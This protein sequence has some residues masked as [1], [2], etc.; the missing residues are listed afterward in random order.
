MSKSRLT[1]LCLVAALAA[2]CGADGESVVAEAV[3]ESTWSA[4]RWSLGSTT[5]RGVEFHEAAPGFE[6]VTGEWVFD[7]VGAEERAVVRQDAKNASPVF[8]V[9]L[10]D[11]TAL[12]LELEVQ[13][14]AVDGQIDQGG[15]LVW[16]AKDGENYYIA[17]FN[18]L[19][20]NYRVYT[21]VDGVRTQLA[22]AEATIDPGAWIA[23]TVSMR[24]DH[25]QCEL[26]GRRLLDVRDDT[27]RDGGRVGLWTKADART[28]FDDLVLRA[29]GR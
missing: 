19:E 20:N 18:P 26:D 15:G 8:N 6:I 29:L 22:S 10:A 7:T 2:S 5:L 9:A 14:R 28:E 13:L 27:F 25:I 4:E 16:R 3:A 23:L 12:D 24:G 21:V 11:R 17:R 1:G